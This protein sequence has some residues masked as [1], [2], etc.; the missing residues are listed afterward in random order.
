[1]L[2]LPVI[3]TE[4]YPKGLGP[5]LPEIAGLLPGIQPVEKL[6]FSS[7]GE[8]GFRNALEA[9]GRKQVLLAGIEAHICVYQTAIDLLRMGYDVRIVADSVSTRE[10]GN[11]DVC[12]IEMSRRGIGLTTVEMAL[13]ELLRVAGGEK[14]KQLSNIVK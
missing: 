6:C 13:F 5:T 11:R 9:S 2:E 7:C 4:Q 14:F 10:P 1:M 12:L 8:E 3:L